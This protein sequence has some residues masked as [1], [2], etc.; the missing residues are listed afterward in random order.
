MLP[1]A[2]IASAVSR[3]TGRDF[4]IENDR[5][6]G[7]GCINAAHVIESGDR[8]Y[9]VKLN[10]ASLTDM[11][12]AEAAGLEDLSRTATVRVPQP[13]AWGKAD[14]QAFLVLE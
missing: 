9:F 7:G 14:G 11:F 1:A 6:L 8:R 13:I 10:S 4:S 12:A 2:A 3:A 5:P